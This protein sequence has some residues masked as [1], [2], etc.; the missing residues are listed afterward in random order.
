MQALHFKKLTDEEH[1]QVLEWGKEGVGITEIARR[2][3]F[4][5]TKQRIKQ[6]MDQNNI[7]V[8]RVKREKAQK[9]LHSRMFAKWGQKW[10]DKEWRKSAVY[11][12][13]RQKFRSKKHNNSKYEWNLNFG[14]LTFPT[15]CPIL[16]IELDYFAEET[17]QD[18]SPSFDRV[19]SSKGYV[20]G[21]VIIV[22]WRANRIK[23][24]GTAEEHQKIANFMRSY[25]AQ[26]QPPVALQ[27][28][29]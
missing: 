12:A 14:D 23:N 6:I 15:H 24:N 3:G 8:T 5:V 18:N 21:N 25:S 11:E 22:S 27:S 26:Q 9:E 17:H 1:A 2:L 13:M 10:Q 19:D 20:T 4:K 28:D 29:V 7:P 16:S